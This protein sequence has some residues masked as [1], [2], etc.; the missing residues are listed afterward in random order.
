[1]IIDILLNYPATKLLN[2]S[3]T[4]VLSIRE[5]CPVK[6]GARTNTPAL[7]ESRWC[8]PTESTLCLLRTRCFDRAESTATQGGCQGRPPNAAKEQ[9]SDAKER[10]E[11]T[12][13][14]FLAAES[15]V[16]HARRPRRLHEARS[17]KTATE[18]CRKFLLE[19]PHGASSLLRGPLEPRP[20]ADSK[21]HDAAATTPFRSDV[22]GRSRAKVIT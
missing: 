5:T 11:L 22:G 6:W 19:N 1:M 16:Q 14:R 17:R 8:A 13:T 9:I 15:R 4:P 18:E 3:I 12:R 10:R 20:T 7:K 21:V 2:P